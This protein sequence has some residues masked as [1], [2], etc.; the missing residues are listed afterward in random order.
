M[1]PRMPLSPMVRVAQQPLPAQRPV[2][3]G[4]DETIKYEL[5]TDLTQ[6]N[7]GAGRV[8]IELSFLGDLGRDAVEVLREQNIVGSKIW[9]AYR[10]ECNSD[11][12]RFATSLVER[13]PSLLLY[14]HTPRDRIAG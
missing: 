5:M 7:I 14:A 13:D 6:N 8:L 2:P 3:F 12:L 4:H 11:V 1:I 9:Q 10:D